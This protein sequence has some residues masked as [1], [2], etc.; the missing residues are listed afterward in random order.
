MGAERAS[1]IAKVTPFQWTVYDFVKQVSLPFPHP[2]I[3]AE[4]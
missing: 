2:L 3:T 4:R 1:Y